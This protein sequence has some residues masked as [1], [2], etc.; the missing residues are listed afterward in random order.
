VLGLIRAADPNASRETKA[1]DVAMLN[2]IERRIDTEFHGSPDQLLQLR[3]TVGDAYR[4]RGETAAA[5]R[6]YQRAV[7]EASPH[8]PADDLL[9]LTARVRTADFNVTVSMKS[10]LEL[11]GVIE[12]LRSKADIN[13]AAADLLVD[14]LLFQR[15]LSWRFGVP[16][17]PPSDPV[18][19]KRYEREP[20]EIATRYSG[21]GSRQ[22]LKALAPFAG[23]YGKAE[24]VQRLESALE[25]ARKRSDAEG[26][27]EYLQA[28]AIYGKWL[29]ETEQLAAGV[30]VLWEVIENVNLRHGADGLQLEVPYTY[31]G[32]CLHAVGDPTALGFIEPAY[33]IASARERPPS[34]NL[35]RRAG[36]LGNVLINEKRP[37]EAKR[38][39]DV[40][41]ANLEALTDESLRQRFLARQQG[42]LVLAMALLGE[43]EQA[44]KLAQSLV[45]NLNLR[46]AEGY[47]IRV[48]D[49]LSFSQRVNGRPDAAMQTAATIESACAAL[50]LEEAPICLAGALSLRALAAN[51]LGQHALALHL[52]NDALSRAGEL[53]T[54]VD[55][56]DLHAAAGRI[57]LANRRPEQAVDFLRS[58]YGFWLS[59]D[60]KST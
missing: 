13:P 51:E 10:A 23:A 54:R 40:S 2:A 4:N 56:A 57:L 34:L 16:S 19:A 48:L 32:G 3:V 39:I 20:N 5:S 18:E 43:T 46:A 6:V 42:D 27:V 44:E 47:G 31:I 21:E 29:C 24:A 41:I 38:L 9:M 55:T 8:L 50:D 35:M 45:P 17:N 53:W 58:A 60:P 26:S 36:H 15:A 12:I 30:R 33:E 52:I 25:H 59:H 28:L 22:Q 49:A 1:A 7:D 14:S 11:A 37:E